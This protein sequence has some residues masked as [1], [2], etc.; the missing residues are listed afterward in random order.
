VI[1]EEADHHQAA[2]WKTRLSKKP[3]DLRND[4][5]LPVYFANRTREWGMGGCPAG[6]R[7]TWGL[8]EELPT[9]GTPRGRRA[10]EAWSKQPAMGWANFAFRMEEWGRLQAQE[11]DSWDKLASPLDATR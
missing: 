9:H 2:N 5:G 1:S 3:P 8:A 10:R 7:W 6:V 11:D 4:R